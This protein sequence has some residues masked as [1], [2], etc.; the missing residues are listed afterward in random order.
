MYWKRVSVVDA[1]ARALA[2]RHYS[3][4]TPG[5]REFT[6]PGDKVVLLA[7]NDNALWVS[8]RTAPKANLPQPRR[9]NFDCWDNPYFRNESGAIASEM[10]IEALRIT[11]YFWG[12]IIPRDG[13]HTFIDPQKVKPTRRRGVDIWGYC[14]L[15]AGFILYPDKTKINQYFRFIYPAE[16]L[17]ALDP[18]KPPALEQLELF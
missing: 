15:K 18:I 11:V 8:H 4:K 9:D 10:I 5:H 1:R 3:R 16:K 17:A 13:F 6:P 2:D 7:I 14:Y 12:G